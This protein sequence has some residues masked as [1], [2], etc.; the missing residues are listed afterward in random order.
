MPVNSEKLCICDV[1]PR[2]TT[3]TAI[4]RD[5]IVKNKRYRKVKREF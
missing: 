1:K 4:Q 5:K 2:A 3:K